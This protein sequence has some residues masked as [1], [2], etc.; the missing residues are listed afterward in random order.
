MPVKTLATRLAGLAALILCASA[1]APF[2]R[3]QAP[4]KALTKQDVIRLL[5]GDVA[6]KRVAAIARERGIDFQMTT[7]VEGDLRQA[8]TT[9]EL[10]KALREISPKPLAPP[11]LEIQS[12]PGH[13]QVY[14]DDAFSG[15]TSDQGRLKV[16]NLAPGNHRVRLTHDG[17]HDDEQAIDLVAG[18]TASVSASLKTIGT[19]T[20]TLTP[21]LISIE[22]G[23]TVT[24]S[25]SS[26]NATEFDLEPGVGR[27]EP[28]GSRTFKPLD[29]TSY[30]LTAKGSGG[31]ASA[32]A[33]VTV[34]LPPPPPPPPPPKVV[35][36]PE[37]VRIGQ[38]HRERGEAILF[39]KDSN[40]KRRGEN[41]IPELREAIRL[42]PH[43]YLAH[44]TLG[45]ALFWRKDTDEAINELEGA[46][47]LEPS[48]PGAHC[49]LG[50][51][52]ATRCRYDAA[53]VELRESIRLNPK[54]AGCHEDLASALRETGD[55]DGAVAEEREA[56]RL[57]PGSDLR[58]YRLGVLLEKRRDLQ[59]AL[60]EYREACRISS[61]MF[62]G[63]DD[64]KRL[65][66]KLR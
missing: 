30:T 17:Y 35:E 2:A 25:W 36:V 22:K 24:L 52:L 29:S 14:V 40:L 56:V 46:I 12:K 51:A 34:T 62:M 28:R 63:C 48:Y 13:A 21:E 37:N 27:V 49:F 26:E 66:K 45:L 23:Q 4:P 11:V 39:G 57:E 5:K 50:E 53:V 20:L 43:D 61:N 41:A 15:E 18:Q 65:Q 7:E 55:L 60:S 16:L 6:P 47:R 58:H 9:E 10:L 54:L 64:Y 19:T 38:E 1:V 33:R 44:T 42:N 8:G 59:S 32:S 3:P 31:T